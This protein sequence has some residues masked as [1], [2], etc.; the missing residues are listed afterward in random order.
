MG[1]PDDWTRYGVMDGEVVETSNT[2]RYRMAGNGIIP[3]VVEEI[4]RRLLVNG[5]EQ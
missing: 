5:V 1:L 4:L 3:A 2:Q